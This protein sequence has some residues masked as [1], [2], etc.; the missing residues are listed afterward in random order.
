[1][2]ELLKYLSAAVI[3]GLIVLAIVNSAAGDKALGAQVQNDKFIF[4]GGIQTSGITNT[5]NVSTTGNSTVSGT[6][7][8][9]GISQIGN[10]AS[11]TLKV[12]AASK[13]GCLVLGDSANGSSPVYIIA[14]GSTIT[15]STTKPVAC[16]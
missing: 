11:S 13:S 2:K 15:A 5:G 8:V 6:L 12:G 10:T 7:T 9:N 4:T 16:Q 14:S 3:G 1:M